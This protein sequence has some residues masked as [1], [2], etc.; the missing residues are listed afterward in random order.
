M[1]DHRFGD[2]TPIEITDRVHDMNISHV[3]RAPRPM[4]SRR[5]AKAKIARAS[6]K[7]NRP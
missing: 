6:R 2:P 3:W 4:G 5:K 7:R 1:R